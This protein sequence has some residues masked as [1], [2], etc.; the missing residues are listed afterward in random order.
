MDDMETQTARDWVIGQQGKRNRA[1]N[2]LIDFVSRKG[3]EGKAIT[4]EIRVEEPANPHG[5]HPF[6]ESYE[7][8]EFL[9]EV[10]YRG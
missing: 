3:Q 1:V 6:G 8:T 4:I 2:R 10:P 5:V 7:M 9:P